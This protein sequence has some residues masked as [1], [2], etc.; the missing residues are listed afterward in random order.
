VL[1]SLGGKLKKILSIVIIFVV[2]LAFT[3]CIDVKTKIIVN[4]N[5]SGTVEETVLM[6]TEMVQMLKQF[7]SGFAD[8]STDVKEFNLYNEEDLKNRAS[9]FGKGVQFLGGEALKKEGREGY[10]SRYSFENLNELKFNQNPSNVM[11]DEMESS[12]QEQTEYII[13]S[14]FKGDESEIIVN[15]PPASKEIEDINLS[16]DSS[17][18]SDLSRIKS[19]MKDLQISLIVE[20]NG[21]ITETNADYIDGSSVTL[22]DLDFSALL[23]DTEKLEE[24]KK[25]NPNN[26]Q[27]LKEIIKDI[28]GISIETNNPVKIKFR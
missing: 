27:D 13:F 16:T 19:I 12:Q 17:D 21:E 8:D 10:I 28:P 25:I 3:G 15:M 5:G 4:K 20:V 9:D 26:L 1:K 2:V 22:F 11:P 23:D 6:S 7:I 18:I 24:I 14:F